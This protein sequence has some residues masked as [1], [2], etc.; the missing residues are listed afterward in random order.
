MAGTIV[1]N[2]VV[3]FFDNNGNPLAGGKITTY[4]S[5]TTTPAS[6]WQNE[7][8]SVLNTNPIVLNSRGEA[9]IWLTPDVQY[10]FV[11]TDANDN[12]IQTVNDIYGAFQAING[13]NASLVNYTPAGTGVVATTQEEYNQRTIFLQDYMT[14]AQKMDVYLRTGLIDISDAVQK[15]CDFA[16]STQQFLTGPLNNARVIRAPR[17]RY[18]LN[19]KVI[20]RSGV[21]IL[22]DGPDTKFVVN[23]GYAQDRL[24]DLGVAATTTSYCGFENLA[25]EIPSSLTAWAIKASSVNVLNSYFRE[26]TFSA[27]YGIS[28]ET[29]SQA[30]IFEG[31][32]SLGQLDC[33]LRAS[34]NWNKVERVDKEGPTGTTTEPYIDILAGDSWEFDNILLEGTGSVNKPLMRI[35][36]LKVTFGDLWF[37]ASATNGFAIELSNAIQVNFNGSYQTFTNANMK[38]KITNC[39]SVRMNQVELDNTT[40]YDRVTIDANSS[41]VIGHLNSRYGHF[42]DPRVPQIKVLR[43]DCR[44]VYNAVKA[45]TA[46]NVLQKIDNTQGYSGNFFRNP[47][48]EFGMRNWGFNGSGTVTTL[49]VLPSEVS[50]GL[51]AHIVMSGASTR[52][53]VQNFTIGAEKIG[54]TVSV[55]MMVRKGA[56][57]PGFIQGLLTG[58]GIS[59]S[60]LFFRHESERWALISCSG[61]IAS[62][63]TLTAGVQAIGFTEIYMD[64]ACFNFGQDARNFIPSVG[65]IDFL[66]TSIAFETSVPTNGIFKRGDIVFNSTPTAGGKIGWVCVTGGDFSGVPPVFKTWG[67]IDP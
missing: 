64:D 9:T 66:N 39:R 28:I 46:S 65:Q 47:S 14:E 5:N 41:L 18:L 37:E 24:F 36:A 40:I 35:N 19:N 56:G 51:M 43:S 16:A 42:A 53:A 31:L 54:S 13:I 20:V 27:R 8:L 4:L 22:G 34:G 15:A 49:E 52:Q 57:T 17:G 60:T 59:S 33:L 12:L 25:F 11:L 62:A 21:Q 2:P 7:G 44:E 23:S 55:S 1:N 48:F 3:Q 26:L 58:C 50:N 29:Y 30:N 32:Y 45:A 10:T 61:T 67:P 38:L 63:G 6:T